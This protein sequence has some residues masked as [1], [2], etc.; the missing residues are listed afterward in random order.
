VT[1]HGPG[2]E[3][4]FAKAL[5]AAGGP[6]IRAAFSKYSQPG[7]Q[8]MG[9]VLSRDLFQS[10]NLDNN[11]E[12][13][14]WDDGNPVL[15]AKIVIQTDERDGGPDEDGNPDDGKR[16]IIIKWWGDDLKALKEA[17]GQN[18]LKPGG[19]FIA[20]FDHEEAPTRKGFNGRKVYAYAYEPPAFTE[21]APP[22][23]QQAQP[24]A[25]QQP[26]AAYQQPPAQQAPPP[27]QYAAQPTG[28]FTPG[29]TET[30]VTQQPPAQAAPPQQ[31]TPQD[32][33]N[34]INQGYTDPDIVQ[35]TGVSPEQVA[36]V[37]SMYAPQG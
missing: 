30:L 16:Y 18:D 12:L 17:V 34:L 13:E 26:P 10:R 4:P 14:T 7:E 3:D 28:G 25:Y 24:A 23:A 33:A 22:P 9:K 5:A 19:T 20:R 2:A 8:H 27:Q 21:S 15:K 36:F 1:F 29:Y 11:N 37:R 32:I 35:Q 6:K 31:A